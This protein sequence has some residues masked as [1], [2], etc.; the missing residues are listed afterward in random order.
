MFKEIGWAYGKLN[1]L[2]HKILNP[3]LKDKGEFMGGCLWRS[4]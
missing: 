3:K 1:K 2:I 4:G